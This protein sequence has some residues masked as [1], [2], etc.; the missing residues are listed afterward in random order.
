[1]NMI[2]AT[3][4]E[5][6]LGPKRVDK[7]AIDA[8]RNSTFQ[9]NLFGNASSRKNLGIEKH[10]GAEAASVILNINHGNIEINV[11]SLL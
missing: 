11:L 1:M 5:M 6:K 2:E 9:H 3:P 7:E 10:A 8:F 4:T